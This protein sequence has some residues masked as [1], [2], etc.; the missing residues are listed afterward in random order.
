MDK[1][2]NRYLDAK[3]RIP[4]VSQLLSKRPEQYATG[5]WPCYHSKAKGCEVWDL[6]NK[7]YYDMTTNGIG[8]CLLGFA[9]DV[10]T[11]AV[12]ERVQNGSMCSQNPIEELEL[13]ERLCQI[14][15]W[16]QQVRFARGGGEIASVAARIA[17]A[18]T[19]R[20]VVA[21]C[22]YHGWTDFYIAVNLGESADQRGKVLQGMCP[23]GVPESL[24]GT[25]VA[26][27]YG[28]K[29]E[30][31][32]V[33]A[34]YGHRLAC[35]MMETARGND[36]EPGF[37]EHIRAETKRVGALLILDEITIG[38]RNCYGGYHLK[39]GITPD[40]AIFGKA[41]GNGHPISAVIGTKEAMEGA[42]R[43][44]ISSTYWTESVGPAAA[45]ATLAEME[46]TKV[47]EHVWRIG[48]DVT[49]M[50]DRLGKKHN[51]PLHAG[52]SYPTLAHVEF[53]EHTMELKT[54][55]TRLM[56]NEGF[57]ASNGFYP[58]LAHTDEVVDKFTVACDKVFGE[59][60]EILKRGDLEKAL[61][62]DI[63]EG[64]FARLIK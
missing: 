20:D 64:D 60:A 51:L 17:R 2:L 31:D 27:N 50:W 34:K 25:T 26:F 22:G 15:P 5:Y 59:I 42:T 8:A 55:F 53:T 47:W 18:T 11:K 4:G 14:H 10:V 28:N 37:L 38:W 39:L 52:G 16:A 33:I 19:G 6:D 1:T 62:T 32:E 21:I 46:R 45:L 49:N 54:L 24:R 30:F 13:A 61:Q 3:E 7:H 36:P 12:V 23:D 57:L 58:T 44:F 56:L 29:A 43:A 63:C 40:M 41:L 48:T 9:N 35:V